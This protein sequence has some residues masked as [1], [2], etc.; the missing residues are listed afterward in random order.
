MQVKASTRP[1][2]VDAGKPSTPAVGVLHRLHTGEELP[3]RILDRY[4]P[5]KIERSGFDGD[6]NAEERTMVET[7]HRFAREVLRPAGRTLDRL[8]AAEVIAP[9]S[10]LWSVY[11]EYAK[12]GIDMGMLDEL[13]PAAAARLECLIVE[14]L[15]W[16]D[17]GLALSL[18]VAGFPLQVAQATGKDELIALARERIGCWPVTQPDHGSD[19]VDAYGV[20]RHPGSTLRAGNVVA[21]FGSDEITIKGQTSAWVSNGSIAQLAVLCCPADYGEGV[22]RADGMRNQCVV[23]VPLDLPGV[24]RGKPLEK[25]GQIT[26]PQGEIFFDEVRVPR[27]YAVCEGEAGIP[28]FLSILSVAGVFMSQV[29]TGLARA[30]FE[31]ALAYAHERRQ[32]GATLIEHQLVRYRLGEMY[33]KI[34]AARAMTRRA[35]HYLRAAPAP[36]PTVSSTAK[37]FVTQVGLEV[38]NEALQLFAGNGLTKEYPLEKLVRDARSSLIEDGENYML[39]MRLGSV[40]SDL[41][42]RDWARD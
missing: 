8:T 25:L 19:M 38:A 21:R 29:F 15:A 3:M 32:G 41:H 18:G 5:P 42:R 28:G 12:L 33:K 24:S 27:R 1:L 34:E 13:E 40:L 9:A 6:L 11:A 10:P 39:T 7:V 36:H 23:M 4:A 30:A 14:E 2:R 37:A 26:L 16:G 17:A 35:A 22:L 20:E 31:H